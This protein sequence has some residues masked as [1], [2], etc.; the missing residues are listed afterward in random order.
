MLKLLH[1]SDW[2]LGKVFKETTFNLLDIQK[3]ILYEIL[4]IAE[5]EKPDIVLIAG[6]IFDTYTPSFEAEKVFY[7]SVADLSAR[8]SL[9]IAL[10]GN[11]DSPE[12][13]LISR[14]LIDGKH[15]IIIISDPAEDFSNYNFE[16]ESF[17][18]SIERDFFKILIKNK[19]LVVAVKAIPYVSEVRT[20]LNT[21]VFLNRVKEIMSPE[22]GFTCD[23]FIFSSHIYIQGAQISGSERI[24]QIGGIDYLPLE[25]LPENADYIA[26]GH[27]HRYQKIGKAVYS[28][29][30]YPFD[31]GEI[32]HKKG[33]CVF[34]GENEK[35]IEFENK[36]IPKIIK[37][38]FETIEDAING[39][40]DGDNPCY[41]IIKSNREYSP[42]D[43][44]RFLKTYKQRL[45]KWR[46][47][48][49]Q[50]EEDI[51]NIDVSSLT[52]EQIF[53]EYFR[54]KISI[55]PDR[56]TISMFL[57]CLEETRNATNQSLY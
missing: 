56:Q 25:I 18:I 50:S 36:N 31:I 2:H 30:I 16:N 35:F 52:D 32:T 48:I 51:P 7:S 40:P 12:K 13:L 22:P 47:D 19:N 37:L 17:R 57:K 3:L 15:P 38:E 41:V 1:T 27:L 29:S 24:L 26:L 6:D 14:P 55:Q 4:K 53:I 46:F 8:G 39:I 34:E 44:D 33:V 21:E 9:V 20:G 42:S 11:H 49:E 45:I 28:G 10:A 43:I 5:I 54:S 23:Y